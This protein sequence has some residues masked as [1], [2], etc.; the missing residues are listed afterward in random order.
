MRMATLPICTG[1]MA[2]LYAAGG[3]HGR[4]GLVKK[5]AN[6]TD[7]S[8]FTCVRAVLMYEL[9]TGVSL[10]TGPVSPVCAGGAHVRVGDW[11][12]PRYLIPS[13]LYPRQA[14][15]MY[16]LATGVSPWGAGDDDDMCVLRRIAGD[17][18]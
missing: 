10:C 14:V 4:A 1:R 9:A 17:I 15:L 12:L 6:C 7:S 11:S 8:H 2:L 5:V 13:P 16:E 18:Q 3:A